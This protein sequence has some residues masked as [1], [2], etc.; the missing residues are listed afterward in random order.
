[1]ERLGID[2]PFLWKVPDHCSGFLSDNHDGSRFRK[3]WLRQNV[4]LFRYAKEREIGHRGVGLLAQEP[5]RG[6]GEFHRGY[7]AE[8]VKP[9]VAQQAECLVGDDIDTGQ[10]TES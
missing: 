10:G 4:W 5:F 1:M 3:P 2:A 9:P 8:A 6:P 7:P